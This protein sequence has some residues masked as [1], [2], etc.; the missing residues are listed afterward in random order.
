MTMSMESSSK[1]NEGGKTRSARRSASRK[2]K[3][4]AMLFEDGSGHIPA[5]VAVAG[6]EGSTPAAH[7]AAPQTP[8]SWAS[9]ELSPKPPSVRESA[10]WLGICGGGWI[11]AARRSA[12][13]AELPDNNPG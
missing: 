3:Y 1:T 13:E 5:A 12:E 7:H 2:P 11:W 8:V 9:Q 4:S 6:V 10:A